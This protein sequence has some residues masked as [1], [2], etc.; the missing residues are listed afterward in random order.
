MTGSWELAHLSILGIQEWF[1]KTQKN[2]VNVNHETVRRN[3]IK[4]NL[5]CM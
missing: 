5:N 1:G 2:G 3:S 4:V